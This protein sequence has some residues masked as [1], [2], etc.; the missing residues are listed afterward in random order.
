[1]SGPLASVIVPNRNGARVLDRCLRQLHDQD[2]EPFEIIVVDDASTDE[3]IRVAERHLDGERLTIVRSERHRGLG[4]ARNLGFRHARG[5]HVAYIDADGYAASDWLRQG[6]ARLEGDPALGAVASLV[7]FD[8]NRTVLNG[9][10]GTMNRYGYGRDYGFNEP[11]EY[12]RLPTEVVYPMGCGMIVRREALERVGGFDPLFTNYYD[13]AEL[14]LKLWRAGYR[15]ELAA[16]AWIDHGYGHSGETSPEKM[17][18]C[19]RHRI[20]TVLKHYPLRGL[21]RWLMREAA[22][23][24][25]FPSIER[26][27]RRA[28]WWWNLPRLPSAALARARLRPANGRRPPY[29]PDPAPV[30]PPTQLS[31]PSPEHAR[32]KL[33]LDGVTDVGALLYG[34]YP[35]QTYEGRRFRWVTAHGALLV[36]PRRETHRLAI[37]YM[38]ALPGTH[39]TVE[40]RPIDERECIWSGPLTGGEPFSWVRAELP[41]RVRAGAY[42]VALSVSGTARSVDG[43]VLGIGLASV[44]L[45]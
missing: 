8:G 42:V 22:S 36:R 7:F 33:Q 17:L 43:A 5:R 39:V 35:A 10:G 21:P 13:D 3:S 11:L 31:R 25:G 40:I 18:F 44:E 16:D 9:A 2:H 15:V 24:T 26:T 1:M 34:F 28:A 37:E 19:E 32:S 6:I 30:P 12:A 38:V 20:R 41:A 4:A 27:R 23:L 29:S 45:T 14:G